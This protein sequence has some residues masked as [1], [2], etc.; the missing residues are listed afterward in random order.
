[1]YLSESIVNNMLKLIEISKDV[2]SSDD[3]S[4]ESMDIIHEIADECSSIEINEDLTVGRDEYL[5]CAKDP[6]AVWLDILNKI[7]DA[8]T[9]IHRDFVIV[10]LMPILDKMLAERVA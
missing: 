2:R 1:M 9:S 3:F 7:C 5:D 10:M 4:K 8:P 6:Y